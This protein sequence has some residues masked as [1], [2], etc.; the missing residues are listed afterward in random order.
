MYANFK[1]YMAFT[2]VEV[3]I[4][5]GIIGVV[6]AITIPALME[7]TQDAEFKSA[8]K[9]TYSLLSN[10][11]LRVKE[12]NG[13]TLVKFFLSA[14]SD[15]ARDKFLQYLSYR[16]VCN[17]DSTSTDCW[18][19]NDVAES[20]SYTYPNSSRAVLNNGILLS[21]WHAQA[22]ENCANTVWSP[23]PE[24]FCMV[25]V[26]DTNGFRGPNLGGKD[27]FQLWITKNGIAPAV[28]PLPGIAF[29]GTIEQDY[30]M[31]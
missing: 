9:K 7:N 5:L 17:V 12:D 24:G 27:I 31:K 14:D 10:A 13:G 25:V 29:R 30:L 19:N 22:D 11:A 2:L 15:T 16:E 6:A 3:L 26:V 18:S 23:P 1:R 28:L 21:F 8:F 20:G 4:T